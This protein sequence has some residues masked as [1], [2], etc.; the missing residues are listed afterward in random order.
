MHFKTGSIG[1]TS[2]SSSGISF[3]PKKSEINGASS[4]LLCGETFS[5]YIYLFLLV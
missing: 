5:S 4:S 1:P 2:I 3:L